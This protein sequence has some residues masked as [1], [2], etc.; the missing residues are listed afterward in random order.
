MWTYKMI[1]CWSFQL[2][3]Y[4]FVIILAQAYLCIP[5]PGA[6][7]SQPVVSPPVYLGGPLGGECMC[8]QVLLCTCTTVLGI[9]TK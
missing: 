8:V 1:P 6:D 9:A 7:P 2:L 5:W 3:H 4:E